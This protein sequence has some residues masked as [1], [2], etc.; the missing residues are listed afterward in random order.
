M[1]EATSHVRARVRRRRRALAAAALRASTCVLLVFVGLALFPIYFMVVNASR[2]SGE[3]LTNPYGPPRDPTLG[4]LSEA[5][6]RRRLL[7]WLQNSFLLH[8]VSVV[9]LDRVAALG[10]L[11]DRAHAL[12]AGRLAA[13]S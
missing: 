1:S 6:P 8:D 10:R 2:P 13:A 4:T 11:S 12:A 7:R 3:Y 9:L 5:L